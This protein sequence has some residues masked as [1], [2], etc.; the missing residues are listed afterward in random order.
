VDKLGV[1][2]GRILCA[3]FSNKA[4][5]VTR[6]LEIALV[7]AGIPCTLYSGVQFYERTEVKSGV[8][9]FGV[10]LMATN[11]SIHSSR[12]FFMGSSS[13]PRT[14]PCRPSRRAA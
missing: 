13:L 1:M 5:N 14:A 4:A 12:V 11:S 9:R 10:W 7:R 6:E 8:S 3:T 2:P